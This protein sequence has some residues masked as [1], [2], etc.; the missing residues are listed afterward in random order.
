[1]PSPERIEDTAMGGVRDYPT[2]QIERQPGDLEVPLQ[3]MVVRLPKEPMSIN[4][5]PYAINVDAEKLAS[6]VNALRI[7]SSSPGHYEPRSLSVVYGESLP[8]KIAGTDNIADAPTFSWEST[9]LRIV[10]PQEIVKSKQPDAL[11][12]TKVQGFLNDELL[13]GLTEAWTMKNW[14]S[15]SLGLRYSSIA[16]AAMVGDGAGIVIGDGSLPQALWQGSLGALAGSVGMATAIGL[17]TEYDKIRHDGDTISASLA[18]GA[19]KRAAKIR[20]DPQ[21][22]VL[23]KEY[24][25]EPIILVAPDKGPELQSVA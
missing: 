15:L 6:A 7:T 8:P 20:Q 13:N 14:R 9:G 19:L 22:R 3:T 4:G 21:K 18:H 23:P 16:V 24:Y 11:L 5:V 10:T 12:A 1:M 25:A 2:D 17:K